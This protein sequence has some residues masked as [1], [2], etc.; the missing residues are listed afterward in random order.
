MVGLGIK[1][2]AGQWD[3]Q[4]RSVVK[5]PNAKLLN[6]KIQN[7]KAELERDITRAEYLGTHIKAMRVKAIVEGKKPGTDF[8]AYVEE[9]LKEKCTNGGTI[10]HIESEVRKL[11]RFAPVLSFGDIDKRFLER[12]HKHMQVALKNKGNT[13]WKSLKFIRTFVNDADA[14]GGS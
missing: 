13:P 8:Y 3:D 11:K 12:W 6:Q 2:S 9:R 4:K 7:K 10:R 14:V 5:H 1:I